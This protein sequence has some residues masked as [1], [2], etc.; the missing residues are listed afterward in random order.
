MDRNKV[1]ISDYFWAYEMACPC[2]GRLIIRMPLC[3]AMDEIR[4]D[5]GRSISPTSWC[6]CIFHNSE[7]YQA[8]RFQNE[9]AGITKKLKTNKTSPHIIGKGPGIIDF[10][11]WAV[12]YPVTYDLVE[13]D[14]REDWMKSL[15]VVGVGWAATFTHIDTKPRPGVAFRSWIYNDGRATARTVKER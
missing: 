5:H 14:D 2:C 6:R 10:G 9:L 11:G 12:D 7:V 4:E 13:L 15:G 8:K 3:A 1:Q